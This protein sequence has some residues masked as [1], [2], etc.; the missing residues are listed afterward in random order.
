M[1]IGDLVRWTHPESLDTGIVTRL[2]GNTAY[3]AWQVEPQ[4]NGGYTFP[5]KHLE[6]LNEDR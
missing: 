2:D 4:H 1:K 6:L 5:H 3:I